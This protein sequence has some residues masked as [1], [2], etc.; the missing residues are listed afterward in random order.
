MTCCR[1]FNRTNVTG[2]I[3]VCRRITASPT[4]LARA[5]HVDALVAPR[6]DDGGVFAAGQVVGMAQ[7]VRAKIGLL[8]LK[9]L[10]LS[11]NIAESICRV[12]VSSI[13]HPSIPY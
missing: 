1:S 11:P 12:S 9:L 5:L 13:C 3:V 6:G 7:Q 8:P 4:S 2:V 10:D